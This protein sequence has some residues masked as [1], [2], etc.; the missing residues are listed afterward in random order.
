MPSLYE[1]YVNS[2][3]IRVV[4]EWTLS[5]AMGSD[6]ASKMEDH[7]KTFVVSF[8]IISLETSLCSYTQ[9]EEDFAEIAGV[10]F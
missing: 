5:Q 1:E 6:L 9:T 3:S 7:Y 10:C 4:D 2:S 8:L